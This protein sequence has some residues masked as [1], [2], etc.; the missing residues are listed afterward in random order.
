MATTLIA[1]V[2]SFLK[3]PQQKQKQ[4]QQPPKRQSSWTTLRTEIWDDMMSSQEESS[5]LSSSVVRL[6]PLLGA[7]L[8]IDALQ[9]PAVSTTFVPE[10]KEEEVQLPAE[11]PHQGVPRS[12]EIASSS[13]TSSPVASTAALVEDQHH[14]VSPPSPL[15]VT[16]N[17]E[18]DEYGMERQSPQALETPMPQ[19]PSPSSSL[20]PSPTV[21]DAR[22]LE[23]LLLQEQHQQ[24]QDNQQ[25]KKKKTSKR[26]KAAAR[27]VFHLGSKKGSSS[28]SITS[29]L[30]LTLSG[31]K[32][33]K[34]LKGITVNTGLQS[35]ISSMPSFAEEDDWVAPSATET[36][37]ATLTPMNHSIDNNEAAVLAAT[38]KT[39]QQQETAIHQET[40]R[41]RQK[42]KEQEKTV[43][44]THG[45]IGQLQSQLATSIE[46]YQAQLASLQ[47]TQQQ[48]EKLALSATL[49]LPQ[50]EQQ[51]Q[52][53]PFAKQ[54]PKLFKRSESGTFMRVRDL[55][56]TTRASQQRDDPSLSSL[57]QSGHSSSIPAAPEVTP[58]FLLMDHYLLEIAQQLTQV[59][60]DLATDESSRFTPTRETARCIAQ[61]PA[62][63]TGT[64][65]GWPLTPWI[66][67]WSNNIL[68][69][70]GHVSHDGFGHTW[71][72]IK[73]RAILHTSAKNVL[74]YLWDSK[75][76]PLYNPLCQGRQDIYT[77][78]DNVDLTANESEF[79]FP[80]SA[81]IVK[82]LNKHRLL[83][84][85][86]ELKSL[87][88][89]RPLEQHQGSYILVSRSVWETAA[90]T[91]DPVA[92]KSV[93]RTEMLTGCTIMR[94]LDDNTCEMTQMTH[95]HLPGAPQMLATR[96]APGQCSNLMGALQALFPAPK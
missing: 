53:T 2:P 30:S 91:L 87:L 22:E 17:A 65:N 13:S 21:E 8:G 77:W 40:E 58:E 37:T 7:L 85:G 31:G 51:H 46:T 96:A 89:A 48:L 16:N 66:P 6:D 64:E 56:L 34:K 62:S 73:G 55:N 23:D 25:K 71:P 19:V 95:V 39:P 69:W 28:K 93:V 29:R 49:P 86:I 12:V 92:A 14:P 27:A 33:S 26:L 43:Q 54:K 63:V 60:F 80:G 61:T 79:G 36:T 70:T 90:A 84:K 75:R 59:G 10:E 38:P 1:A 3:A 52:C 32:K 50:T 4:K 35:P 42:A 18:D 11:Q 15:A 74:N 72:I 45:V 47:E 20:P 76:V 88:Y 82:S 9:L 67:T 24:Q 83:P 41:L 5:D 81:K 44:T 78:Q 68:V 57:S 94:A